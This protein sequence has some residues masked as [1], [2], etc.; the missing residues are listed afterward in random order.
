MKII[1]ITTGVSKTGNMLVLGL[2]D[3]N[4][5]YAWLGEGWIYYQKTDVYFD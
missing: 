2:G 3:D 1:Q 4:R 5:V